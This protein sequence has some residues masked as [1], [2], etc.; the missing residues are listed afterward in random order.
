M[1]QQIVTEIT[2]RA[3]ATEFAVVLPGEHPRATEIAVDALDM[4][5]RIEATLSIYRPESEVSRIN[6]AAG[7]SPVTVSPEVFDLITR[8][9][10]ISQWTDGAFDITAGPLVDCWGFTKRR[11]QKPSEEQIAAARDKVGWNRIE[12]IKE[13][14]QVFLP[15]AGMSLNLG[16]IGKGY[17]IDRLASHLKNNGIEHFLIH[18]GKSTIL[19]STPATLADGESWKIAIEHPLRPGQRLTQISVDNAAIATSGSGKQFFHYRGKRL[20]HVIDPRTGYPTGDALSMTIMT[21]NATDADALSTAFF[22]QG[23]EATRHQLRE[24][25]ESNQAKPGRPNI[26]KVIAVCEVTGQN[27]VKVETIHHA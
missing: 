20:G 6:T 12:L 13:A 14:N 16:G 23:I 18:G 26:H 10:T 19:A 21:D 2:H 8:A 22:V 9:V 15:K 25:S 24:S 5:D 11:G 4:L 17:A 27:E 7:T 1:N 3:M